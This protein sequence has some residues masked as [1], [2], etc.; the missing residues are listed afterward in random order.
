MVFFTENASIGVKGNPSQSELKTTKSH[1]AIIFLISERLT[2]F[3]YKNAQI[4][5][6]GEKVKENLLKF[7]NLPENR[8]YV[9]RNAVEPFDG[10]ITPLKVIGN[11]YMFYPHK[12]QL[13]YAVAAA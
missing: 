8:V 7:Y 5:A 13:F 10:E 3:A 1:C 12:F 11:G 6:V 9:L 4:F 2:R